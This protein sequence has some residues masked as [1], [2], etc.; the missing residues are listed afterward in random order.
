MNKNKLLSVG[1]VLLAL[2]DLILAQANSVIVVMLGVGL[3]GLHMGFTQ[4]ILATMVANA[5]PQ[6]LKGSAF[7]LF[8]FVTGIFMLLA[9]IIAGWLW[10]NAGSETTFYTGAGF[11]MLALLLLLF[12]RK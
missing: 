7:G 6:E 12:D 8:N 11:S 5:T 3:W 2:A 1:L 9:S 10:D 4:G